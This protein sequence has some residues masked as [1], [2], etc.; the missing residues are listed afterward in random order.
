V[1]TVIYQSG[2]WNGFR[3]FAYDHDDCTS[4]KVQLLSH[5]LKS[6]RG[7]CVPMPILFLILTE[8]LGL[9]VALVSAPNHFF[10]RYTSLEG[11]A[12]DLETTSGA[13]P[14]RLEWFRQ[15]MPMSDKALAN[16]L[17]MRSLPRREAIAMMAFTNAWELAAQRR[18]GEAAALCCLILDMYPRTTWALVAA[19]SAYGQMFAEEFADRFPDPFLIPQHLFARRLMLMERNNSLLNA[20]EHLGWEPADLDME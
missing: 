6:G 17:Y 16:G 11:S 7:N 20:A 14:A 4:S 9:D 8:R 3:P 15:E 12:F 13:S 19:G 18:W 1:R 5:Y 2:P 10:V